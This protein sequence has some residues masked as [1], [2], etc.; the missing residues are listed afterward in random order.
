M[1]DKFNDDEAY[2]GIEMIQN[3]NSNF[4]EGKSME[5]VEPGV[6]GIRKYPVV[7]IIVGIIG[8]VVTTIAL[9]SNYKGSKSV[10]D[11]L[12]PITYGFIP[13]VVSFLIIKIGMKELLGLKK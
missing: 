10:S 3:N 5:K 1:G 2:K 4:E 8:M 9:I 7:L 12:L 11:L 13:F 6:K